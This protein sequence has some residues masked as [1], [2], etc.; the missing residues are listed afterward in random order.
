MS[1]WY[2]IVADDSNMS[3]ITVEFH[4]FSPSESDVK[5]IITDKGYVNI[6]SIEED[7]DFENNLK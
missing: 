5:Q 6:Q 1:K 2:R 4:L 3:N 7:K